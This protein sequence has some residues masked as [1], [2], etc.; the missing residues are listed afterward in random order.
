MANLSSPARSSNS[1]GASQPWTNPN[2]TSSPTGKSST[3]HTPASN[4]ALLTA[5]QAER[6]ALDED[7]TLSRAGVVVTPEDGK[8]VLRG[9]VSAEQKSAI[10][11]AAEHAA[12]GQ[13]VESQL[14]TNASR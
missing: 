3:D 13:E 11:A 5:A 4:S 6:K 7:A 8:I 9:S 12:T 14:T 2:A 10:E 1:G